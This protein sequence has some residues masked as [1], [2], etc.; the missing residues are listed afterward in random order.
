MADHFTFSDAP[1]LSVAERADWVDFGKDNYAGVTWDNVSTGQRFTTSW[2]SNWQY[3]GSTP[4][5]PWRGAMTAPRELAM[6]TIDGEVRLTQ[7]PVT[8]LRSLRQG[9]AA[10]ANKLTIS[11]GST[12]LAGGTGDG[13]TLEIDA[14]FHVAGAERFGL[15]LATGPDQETVVGYD[16]VTGELYVDRTR[17]GV[18]DFSPGFA[19]VHRAALAPRDGKIRIKI[20]LDWSSVEVFGGAGEAV[21]TDLIFPDPDS[22]GVEL[23]AEGGSARL[24][25][26]TL[27]HLGSYRD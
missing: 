12:M 11:E 15:K 20:L 3:T 6:R 2:M 17:S 27:R 9:D 23:F 13:R 18:D 8:A 26:L 19:G 16:A 24:D 4:T 22:D 7:E 21:I 1:A 14:T 25:K 5:M 10:T